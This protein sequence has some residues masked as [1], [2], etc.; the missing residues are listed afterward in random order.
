M[1]DWFRE[2]KDARDSRQRIAS[3]E[4]MPE[5]SDNDNQPYSRA[6]RHSEMAGARIAH[7]ISACPWVGDM[8][9]VCPLPN[10]KVSDVGGTLSSHLL[11]LASRT[12]TVG[13]QPLWGQLYGWLP[14]S[15]AYDIY[16]GE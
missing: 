6:F 16:S 3:K 7:I 5:A 11:S 9:S 14:L 13:S 2:Q 1:I 15:N 10:G 12:V 4:K 8:V